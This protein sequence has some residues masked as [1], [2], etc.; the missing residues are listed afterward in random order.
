MFDLLHVVFLCALVSS[1]AWIAWLA[2]A[3]DRD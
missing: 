2:W 1:V 3:C